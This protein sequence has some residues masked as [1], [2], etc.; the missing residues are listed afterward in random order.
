MAHRPRHRAVPSATLPPCDSGILLSIQ[1][2]ML[3]R[4]GRGG[5]R[6]GRA[7][8]SEAIGELS[9]LP[10]WRIVALLVSVVVHILDAVYVYM[11]SIRNGEN[12]SGWLLQYR[13][14]RVSK[15]AINRLQHSTSAKRQSALCRATFF[16]RNIERTSCAKGGTEHFDRRLHGGVVDSGQPLDTWV[17]GCLFSTLF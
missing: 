14:Q 13:V 8:R 10:D 1:E 17:L 4:V 12:C 15:N 7:R 16:V 11:A 9:G 2:N 3:A 5:A 6:R